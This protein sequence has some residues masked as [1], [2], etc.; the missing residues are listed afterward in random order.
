MNRLN[1]PERL[2]MEIFPCSI[3]ESSTHA[4]IYGLNISMLKRRAE[5]TFKDVLNVSHVTGGLME[6]GLIFHC[7]GLLSSDSGLKNLYIKRWM[8][9]RNI[10]VRR[11]SFSFTP[12]NITI[13]INTFG[14]ITRECYS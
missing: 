1:Q 13:V 5:G 12:G 11:V 10:A 14:Q 8:V 3:N 2:F 7:K 9:R 6:M 4:K